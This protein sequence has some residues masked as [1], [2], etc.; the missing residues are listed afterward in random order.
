MP[1]QFRIVGR[2]FTRAQVAAVAHLH[3]TEVPDGF[4]SS[5]GEPVLRL[6]YRHLAT[7]RLGVLYVAEAVPT[8][9]PLGYICG[10]PDTS[11]LFK[12]FVTRRWPLAVPLLI[13]RM[14]N[15]RRAFRLLETVLYPTG[16]AHGLPR[17]EI[18]NFVVVPSLRGRGV[19]GKLFTH[20][21]HWFSEHGE[22]TVKV[23]TG[24]QQQR[25]H[26]FYEKS[27]AV[28]RGRTSIHR[29]ARSR[30][31]VYPICPPGRSSLATLRG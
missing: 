25:A 22:S 29:G 15:P 7:S 4:L 8:G 2:P 14:L 28:L 13:P 30:V 24:E 26:G 9:E 16:P 10:S 12:E 20:L 3:A 1:E 11:A 6:L 23:V 18:I 31:Y 17:A 19:A 21:M 27:G 5:L